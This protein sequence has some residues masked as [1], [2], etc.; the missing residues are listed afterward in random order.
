MGE[1]DVVAQGVEPPGPHAVAAPARELSI[2]DQLL[3]HD[4]VTD[5]LHLGNTRG[6]VTSEDLHE[7]LDTLDLEPER[8][9]ALE[10][11]LRAEGIQLVDVPPADMADG[12]DD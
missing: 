3:S 12:A 5:L 4:E 10:K 2:R 11:L 7:V 9:G 8:S 6:F 1:P